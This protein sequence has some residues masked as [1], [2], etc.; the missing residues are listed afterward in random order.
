MGYELPLQESFPC[1]SIRWKNAFCIIFQIFLFTQIGRKITAFSWLAQMFIAEKCKLPNSIWQNGN[2]IVW[3]RGYPPDWCWIY[4][5]TFAHV[6]WPCS[7]LQERQRPAE[8]GGADA[9]TIAEVV[10]IYQTWQA[11][12][13]DGTAFAKPELYRSVL[14]DVSKLLYR[15]GYPPEW[16]EEVF[17]KVLEQVEN[18]KTYEGEW[19]TRICVCGKIVVP[20]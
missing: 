4:G 3:K 5:L 2:N 15:S 9:R 18:F 19:K 12:G 14:R 6:K 7:H 16:D 1:T 20:L 13:T 8:V 17:R 10:C 11:E